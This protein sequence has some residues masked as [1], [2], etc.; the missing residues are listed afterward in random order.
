MKVPMFRITISFDDEKKLFIPEFQETELS[1][2]FNR[3]EKVD[4]INQSVD[5]IIKAIRSTPDPDTGDQIN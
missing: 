2:T 1:K 3:R 4:I 5:V